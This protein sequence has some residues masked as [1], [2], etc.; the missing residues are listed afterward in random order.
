M[1]DYG[2]GITI[3][4]GT[5]GQSCSI[6]ASGEPSQ[7]DDLADAIK[8]CQSNGVKI[9]LSPGGAIGMYSLSSQGEAETIGQNLWDASGRTQNSCVPRL[10][11]TTFVNGWDFDIEAARGNQYYQ[12]L[13]R[14]LRSNFVSDSSNTYYITGSPQCPIPEPH[15]QQIITSS[16]FD[17]L[18]VQ[19]YKNPSC[20]VNGPIN[21][22]V[23]VSAIAGTPYG[24][25]KI[26]VGVPASP[27]AATGTS[28]GAQYYLEPSTLATLVRRY[29]TNSA[30]GGI[31]MRSSGLSDSNV[32][33]CYTYDQE[34]K[35]IFTTGSPY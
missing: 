8:A 18:W 32:S 22:D 9:I 25:A 24:N 4:S 19:F 27:N 7:C 15:M 11:G 3:P 5:I 13:I 23:W 33:N 20:S 31:A 6:S 1:Y 29:S 34:S 35:R 14:I 28:S 17:H 16:Q 2:N 10:F 26:F 30:F 12:Y 21:Y